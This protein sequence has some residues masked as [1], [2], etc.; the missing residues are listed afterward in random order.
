[1][2]VIVF[3][4]TGSVGR[5]VVEQLLE[6]GHQVTGFARHPERLELQHPALTLAPGDAL[7]P[8][9]VSA[10]VKGHDA[11]IVALGAGASL[12]SRVR[13]EGTRNIIQA[14]QTHG[15]R[16]LICQSTL[17]AGDSWANLNFWWKRVMFGLILRNVFKDHERQEQ[18][19]RDSGLDW[20]IL[21]P[22]AFAD[23]PRAPDLREGFGPDERGLKL[24][25]PRGDVAAGLVRQLSTSDTLHRAVSLST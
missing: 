15:V 16:R 13:S 3:G 7:R 2:R 20:T 23:G 18:L 17:G 5:L 4:A 25:I 14:M 6:A 12:S 9:D 22:S 10:A 19:V 24:T 8:E 21:R 11:V 1:M